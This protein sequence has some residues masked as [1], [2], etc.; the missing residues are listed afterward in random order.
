M[1]SKMKI[2]ADENIPLVVS[3][4]S[5]IGEVHTIQ[6]RNIT[7][8]DLKNIDILLVRSVTKINKHLLENSTVQFVGTA[9]IG[10]DHIDLEYLKQ[11]NIGFAS[12]PGCNA[13]AAAEYVISTLFVLALQKN[14]QLTDKT[15]GIIGCG[16][17][18]ANVL[19]KLQALGVHCLINDPPLA[20]HSKNT[21]FVDLETVLQADIITLHVPLEKSAPYPTYHLVNQDFLS[22]LS[23][24]AILL[25]ASRGDVIDETALMYHLIKRPDLTVAL[26]VWSSEPNINLLLMQKAAIATPHIAGYS[27]DGKLRGTEMLYKAIC[28][29]FQYPTIWQAEDHLPPPNVTELC[30]SEQVS[31]I[32][33]LFTAMMTS[34][35][36]RRDDALLRQMSDYPALYFDKL[37]KNYPMRREFHSLKIKLPNHKKQLYQKF[38]AL[39]FTVL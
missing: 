39:G 8:N 31:D 15:V 14:F 13:N 18:G 33:A 2:L 22:Q 6:G 21:S 10:F 30:F 4:F 34:Y 29:Y 3:A 28:N 35:D 24:Q 27:L 9:T 38:K 17:V 23:D 25:N 5:N 7:P 36:V 11:N 20:Q 16:N 32:N 37:R 1:M 19:Q 26:D 12:A